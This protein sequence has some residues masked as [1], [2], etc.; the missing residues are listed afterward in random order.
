MKNKT[1]IIAITAGLFLLTNAGSC[2]KEKK[3]E[4]ELITTVKVHLKKGAVDAGTFVWKDADGDGGNPPLAPD[5]I[6]MDTGVTY[7]CTLEY[8]NE[9]S[10]PVQ[11]ITAEIQNEAAN[12]R[13]CFSTDLAGSVFNI[14]DSDGKYPIGLKSEWKT[15]AKGTGSIRIVLRHQ[16]NAKDGT[17]NPGD[18]DADVSFPLISK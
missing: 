4:N 9:S 7:A 18:T 15:S 16:P 5:T 17:C 13:I 8:L 2:K 11:D 3:E 10:N 1:I 14:T 6:K 12:H